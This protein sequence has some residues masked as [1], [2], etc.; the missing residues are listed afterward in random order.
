MRRA[1]IT[2]Q[3]VSK[4]GRAASNKANI[5]KYFDLKKNFFEEMEHYSTRVLSNHKTDLQEKQRSLSLKRK[6]LL[7]V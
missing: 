2:I 5:G 7:A 3:F 1:E 6:E 4:L